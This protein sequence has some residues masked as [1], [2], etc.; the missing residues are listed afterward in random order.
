MKNIIIDN[1]H[2]SKDNQS[3]CDFV[4]KTFF[5]P[6]I[7]TIRRGTFQIATGLFNELM[8]MGPGLIIIKKNEDNISD[9]QDKLDSWLKFLLEQSKHPIAHSLLSMHET[10]ERQNRNKRNNG[11]MIFL[12]PKKDY[13]FMFY[14][15]WLIVTECDY[16]KDKYN[17]SIDLEL[18]QQT[19]KEFFETQAMQ[20][21]DADKFGNIFYSQSDEAM[22][23]LMN[24]STDMTKDITEVFNPDMLYF[25]TATIKESINDISES[26]VSGKDREII[27]GSQ[28]LNKELKNMEF[29]IVAMECVKDISCYYTLQMD[30]EEVLDRLIRKR[31]S[32]IIQ[33]EQMPVKTNQ[34]KSFIE[35]FGIT[36]PL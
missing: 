7:E 11:G 9:E 5:P 1:I 33:Y 18:L 29:Q 3:M 32:K 21:D 27:L 25:C 17:C 15:L 30:K 23:S 28:D 4:D 22:R 16:L 34:M 20:S 19:A 14:P 6:E 12:S 8:M 31:G 36:M 26:K 2:S 24:N 35:V 13:I 10:V